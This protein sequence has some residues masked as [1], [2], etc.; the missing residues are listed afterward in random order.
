MIDF[1]KNLVLEA[2][3]V[4]YK[5]AKNIVSEK[6]GVGNFVTEADLAIEKFI[7]DAIHKEYKNH[8]IIAEESDYPDLPSQDA[9]IWFVDP[10]DGTTAAKFGYPSSAISIAYMNNQIIQVGAIYDL[11]KKELFWAG[12]G[13]G[14]FRGE[15]QLYLNEKSLQDGVA[16]TCAPYAYE[17]FLMAE[18]IIDQLFQNKCKIVMTGS[19]AVNCTFVANQNVTLYFEKGLKPWDVAAGSLLVEESGG[20]AESFDGKL[21]IFNPATFVCGNK[22]A[23]NEFREHLSLI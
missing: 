22:L 7:K 3:D 13:K 11:Y 8:F 19:A 20:V 14:V 17:N 1:V 18:K 6:E 12:R 21:D 5:T 9:H 4:F 23:V 16:V 10:L 15:Q 2:S